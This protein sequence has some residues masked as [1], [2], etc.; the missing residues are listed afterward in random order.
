MGLHIAD[1]G[2]GIVVQ[3]SAD[4]QRTNEV[5]V[6]D[7]VD[8]GPRGALVVT[9]TPS[10]Y[11]K[12][13]D[14][15]G[16]PWSQLWAILECGGFNFSKVL[17]VGEGD[18]GAG[19]TRYI[20]A[21]FDREGET[22]P[23]AF[24]VG[25]LFPPSSGGFPVSAEGVRVSGVEFAGIFWV[26]FGTAGAAVSGDASGGRFYLVNIGAREGQAP[27]SAPGLFAMGVV[28]PS[29]APSAN[30][31]MRFDALGTGEAGSL[32]VPTTYKD[33][34]GGANFGSSARQLHP[35]GIIAYNNHVFLWGY[36]A[37]DDRWAAISGITN[38]VNGVVTT[39]A[40]HGFKTGDSVRFRGVDG[41]T[42]INGM[43][44]TVTVTGANTFQ[45]GIDTSAFG[46][47]I[48]GAKD[49]AMVGNGD[50][51]NRVM[52]SNLGRPLKYGN[53]NIAAR[54][55][56]RAF[57]DSDAIMLGDA[58]EIIR[59]GIVWEGKLI[60][61]TNKGLHYIAGYGR[62]SFL[63]DG[64]NPIMRSYN[65]VGP[66]ALVEGPDKALYG[67]GDQGLWCLPSLG[68]VPKP[69]FENLRDYS[70][71]STG[72]WDLIWTD[73]TR[74]A[75]YPGT[76]NQDLVWLAVDWDRQQI[77]IG[78]PWCSIDNGYGYGTD[79]V[80]LKY[81]VR[82]GGFTRQKFPGVQYTAAG[83]F[84]A[85]AQQAAM[86]FLGTPTSG[87]ATIQRYGFNQ[88]LAYSPRDTDVPDSAAIKLGPYGAFGPDGRGVVRRLYTVFSLEGAL[89]VLGTQNI[90]GI[91]NANPAEVTTSVAHNLNT[92]DL[93]E[94]YSVRNNTSMKEIVGGPY[95]ITRTGLLTF[96]LDGVD[97]TLFGVY[98]P[99]GTPLKW[100]QPIVFACQVKVDE[101]T[102]M[103]PSGAS[104]TFAEFMLSIQANFPAQPSEGDLWADLSMDDP[105]IGN[106]TAGTIIQARPG[107]LMRMR[108]NNGAVLITGATKANPCVITAAAHGFTT[109]DRISIS[110]VAG[111]TELNNVADPG[112]YTKDYTVVK[113]DADH[114]SLVGIDSSAYGVYTSGGRAFRAWWQIPRALGGAGN[115]ALSIPVPVPRQSGSRVT[116]EM[117][118]EVL[119]RRWQLEGFGINPGDGVTNE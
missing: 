116:L 32:G 91:T 103:P 68:S 15:P 108:K 61:G 55:T 78:I 92:G 83:Y 1:F 64:A 54:G 4:A 58:G 102:V 37:A 33:G 69:I 96:T 39:A 40:A 46:A 93:V 2:G 19:T 5:L 112:P 20:F 57:T 81:D 31:I 86:K 45:T 79:T 34:E 11:L 59:A 94:I 73:V 62:D 47:Y 95:T 77:I 84:R 26:R 109:G 41:M 13:H 6:A 48:A 110:D 7:N 21:A 65:V 72:Y 118:C 14:Q 66:N 42:E 117:N 30:E 114:F 89:T 29:T 87:S 12:L 99:G 115:T 106:A 88:A 8:I 36:D 10:D 18:A 97:S 70:G 22:S 28:P 38:A 43:T 49:F 101:N 76:T 27:T 63:T 56:D 24:V 23:L 98:A 80:V 74:A 105:N 100:S 44:G 51:P 71:R 90:A 52:F 111:M 119:G 104:T 35:R 25:S 75:T 85:Q 9:T 16:N 60:F 67:L 107:Y 17:A 82:S 113:I 53:D 50:G 3:G